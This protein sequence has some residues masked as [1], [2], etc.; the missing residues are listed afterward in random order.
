MT[1]WYR[2]SDFFKNQLGTS[3]PLLHLCNVRYEIASVFD[4]PRVVIKVGFKPRTQLPYSS[5]KAPTPAEYRPIKLTGCIIIW[6]TL[7][8]FMDTFQKFE[9]EI[10]SPLVGV[11]CHR[12]IHKCLFA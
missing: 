1:M 11:H 8:D 12:S 10:S 9:V 3:F 7:P 6:Y 4:E 5:I 2:G